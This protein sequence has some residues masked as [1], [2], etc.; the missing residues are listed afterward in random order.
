VWE[1]KKIEAWAAN[2]FRDMKRYGIKRQE[3]AE[4]ADYT[5]TYISKVMNG[6][7]KSGSAKERIQSALKELINAKKHNQ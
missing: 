4:K 6:Q 2:A 7:I 3:I 1:V 5:P